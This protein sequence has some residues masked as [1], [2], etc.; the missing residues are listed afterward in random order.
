MTGL[1]AWKE[2]MADL[3]GEEGEGQ[4]IVEFEGVSEADGEHLAKRQV[5][6]EVGAIR[7][8]SIQTDRAHIRS[9][10]DPASLRRGIRWSADGPV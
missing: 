6:C 9:V 3:N 5:C 1:A 2:G 7:Q 4:K 10:T 8:R